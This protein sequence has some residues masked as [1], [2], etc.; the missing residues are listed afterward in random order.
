MI[1]ILINRGR[2]RAMAALACAVA[3][4]GTIGGCSQASGDGDR[5][6]V[7]VTTAILGDVVRSVVGGAADVEVLMPA[8]ASPHDFQPSARQVAAMRA[9]DA[10]VANGGGLEAGVEDALAAAAADGVPVFRAA[11]ADHVGSDAEVGEEVEQPTE[12]A[13]DHDDVES[14]AAHGAEEP[15]HD[16]EHSE[17]AHFFTSPERMIDAVVGLV[18][19]LEAELADVDIRSVRAGAA[20]YVEELEALDREVADLMDGIAAERRQLV[21]NHDVL[22]SFAERYGFEIVGTVLPSSS[23]TAAPSAAAIAGLADLLRTRSIPAVF[24][25]TSASDRLARALAQ[26][27][28]G[29]AVVALHTETLGGEGD[30]DTYLE[31]I[32]SNAQK[33]AEAL[34]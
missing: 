18:A 13:D 3:A 9:A 26:E 32:R 1:S 8:T 28:P 27:V 31:M 25:D 34:R 10:V 2:L 17:D 16:H 4:A 14:D 29:V 6:T 12:P 33:I 5:P 30:A 22:G 15:A 20:A 11:D 24:V 23:T 19:F 7:V 21:T